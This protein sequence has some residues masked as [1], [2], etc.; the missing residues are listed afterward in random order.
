MKITLISI[1]LLCSILAKGQDERPLLIKDSKYLSELRNEFKNHL[2]D[3]KSETSNPNIFTR[4]LKGEKALLD[5]IDLILASNDY[6]LENFLIQSMSYEL[7]I[8]LSLMGACKR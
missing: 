1:I 2:Y 4:Y 5:S 7:P 8:N 3:F 6:N